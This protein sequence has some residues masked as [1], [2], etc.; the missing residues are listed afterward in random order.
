MGP[1]TTE[2]VFT[3]L[4]AAQLAADTDEELVKHMEASL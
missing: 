4:V 3:R 2:T 1:L